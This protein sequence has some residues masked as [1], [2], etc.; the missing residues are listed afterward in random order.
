MMRHRA[1]E[2]GVSLTWGSAP[3]L[4]YLNT[5][6]RRLRQMINN[7]LS[8]AA[9]FT[10]PGGSVRVLAGIEPSRGIYFRVFDDGVGMTAEHLAKA[11]QP[12]WQA[13]S[14]LARSYQGVGLGLALTNQLARLLG[15]SLELQSSPGRGTTATI[16]LPLDA[17]SEP[18]IDE[19]QM[20][21]STSA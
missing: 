7:L 21:I 10:E 20:P 4:A 2:R 14:A 17:L 19:R 11:T 8:N 9:K 3:D 5:D 13:E 6:G 15:G 1:D 16:W 18:P 12:F